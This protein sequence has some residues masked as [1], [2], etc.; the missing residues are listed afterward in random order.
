MQQ[1]CH[2]LRFS[3]DIHFFHIIRHVY[4]SVWSAT[5]A[6]PHFGAALDRSAHDCGTHLLILLSSATWVGGGYING[7]AEAVFNPHGGIAYAFALWAAPA[8]MI[9]SKYDAII[10][11]DKVDSVVHDQEF[12]R[13][14][15]QDSINIM[16]RKYLFSRC[17]SACLLVSV[18]VVVVVV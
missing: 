8:S 9:L 17:R 11:V 10:S 15:N 16:S 13:D 18:V 12:R 2:F 4:G 14:G 5:E 6:K 3:T 7:T 1:A